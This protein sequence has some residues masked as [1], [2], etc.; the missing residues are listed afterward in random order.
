MRTSS[1]PSTC[2]MA[3][4][5]GA[6]LATVP[7]CTG[8]TIWTPRN[9]SPFCSAG[10]MACTGAASSTTRW[11]GRGAWPITTASDAFEMEIDGDTLFEG[12][13]ALVGILG[14]REPRTGPMRCSLMSGSRHP[15]RS[16]GHRPRPPG[17]DTLRHRRPQADRRGL[18]QPLWRSLGPAQARRRPDARGAGGG[19]APRTISPAIAVEP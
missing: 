16:A 10:R 19:G 4:S 9:S 1:V 14:K 3:C 2:C 12:G 8:V 7:C 15:D 17:T 11:P 13:P 18:H 6:R 5:T